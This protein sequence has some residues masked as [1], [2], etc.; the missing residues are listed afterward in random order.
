MRASLE[1]AGVRV[2][3]DC[4]RAWVGDLISEGAAGQLGPSDP[5][6]ASLLLRVEGTR[7]PFP[8]KGWRMVTRGVWQRGAEAVLEDVCTAG[9]D[10]H[11]RVGPERATFTFRW[12]P[13]AR[14]RLAGW[15]LRSRFHLL[16]RAALVQYPALWWTGTRGRVPLHASGVEAVDGTPL[17]TAASGIGRSTLLVHGGRGRARNT[18]DNLGVSDG[19]TLW[20]LVEP[21]RIAGGGGRRMPHGRTEMPM[22]RRVAAL[23]PSCIVALQRGTDRRSTIVPCLAETA[24]RALV[25]NTYTAGELRRYWAFAAALAAATG[26]GPAHPPVAAVAAE[27][28]SSLPCWSL[29]LGREGDA[30]LDHLLPGKAADEWAS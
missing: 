17:V 16:A 10:V 26:H 23:D 7:R 24:A 5:S 28:T 3:I 1:T 20:G 15:V 14:S 22:T 19:E 18:G 25:A 9:F 4:D 8:A 27:L 29:M 21:A 13:P 6:A 12:L 11:V 30:N 2:E